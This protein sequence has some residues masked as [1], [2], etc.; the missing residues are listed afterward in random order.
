MAPHECVANLERACRQLRSSLNQL[1]QQLGL[2]RGACEELDALEAIRSA[3]SREAWAD[4]LT[5]SERRVAILCA[6][7]NSNAE[8][9][10]SLHLSINTVKS[11]LSGALRKLDLR[12]RW[13]LHDLLAEQAKP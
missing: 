11:Q 6:S 13:Q 9:A 12:S 2:L 8:I 10:E 5:R 7:G 3:T 1:D 4:G